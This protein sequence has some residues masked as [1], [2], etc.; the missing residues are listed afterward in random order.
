MGTKEKRIATPKSL[1][2]LNA[3][4]LTRIVKKKPILC[5]KWK[6]INNEKAILFETLKGQ[7]LC[8]IDNCWT[9]PIYKT[10]MHSK[11]P[12]ITNEWHVNS[13]AFIHKIWG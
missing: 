7:T 8:A 12:K 6:T 11:S 3:I 10:S 4:W 1:I 9:H 13:G 2:F 5:Y